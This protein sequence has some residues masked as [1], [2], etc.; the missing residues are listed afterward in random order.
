MNDPRVTAAEHADGT[1]LRVRRYRMMGLP[2]CPYVSIIAGTKVWP[3]CRWL[4]GAG[5]F[6]LSRRAADT[7]ANYVGDSSSTK[8]ILHCHQKDVGKP[9]AT[10]DGG[11]GA[12]RVGHIGSQCL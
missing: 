5:Y 8:A 6:F 11:G 12:E 1:S 2:R 9:N 3:G 7:A 10:A 4:A